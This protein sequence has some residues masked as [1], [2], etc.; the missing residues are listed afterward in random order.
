MT[1]TGSAPKKSAN[2]TWS[3]YAGELVSASRLADA[4][5]VT[6]VTPNPAAM[7]RTS[8]TAS[9]TTGR[10]RNVDS[11]PLR[12][13]SRGRLAAASKEQPQQV[14]VAGVRRRWRR[15]RRGSRHR[16]V[17]TARVRAGLSGGRAAGRPLPGAAGVEADG[18]RAEDRLDA[19]EVPVRVGAGERA[20]RLDHRRHQRGHGR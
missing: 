9:G 11:V 12:R 6:R 8:A 7:E 15:R 14:L 13:M 16:H 3:A 17:G 1:T 19:H 4:S 20:L 5:N 18:A 10:A 2:R